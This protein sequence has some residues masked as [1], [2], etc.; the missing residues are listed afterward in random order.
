[1]SRFI[2]EGPVEYVIFRLQ[3]CWIL[4][5]EQIKKIAAALYKAKDP[6]VQTLALQLDELEDDQVELILPY[7]SHEITTHLDDIPL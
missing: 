4:N 5:D 3:G 2:P 7:L 1:M 6:D